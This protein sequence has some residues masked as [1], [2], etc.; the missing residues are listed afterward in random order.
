MTNID[1]I[2]VIILNIN[3]PEETIKCLKSLYKSTYRDFEVVLVDNGSTDGSVERIKSEFQDSPGRSRFGSEFH[4]GGVEVVAS[5][6]PRCM[7]SKLKIIETGRNLGFHGGV[8]VGLK[9]VLKR[10]PDYILLLNND[11][12]VDKNLLKNLIAG[13]KLDKKIGI[14]G[15]KIYY[16]DD[17]STCSKDRVIWFAGGVIDPVNLTGGHV[18]VGEIDKG[19]YDAPRQVDFIS[20]CCLM[21][22]ADLI[23]KIGLLDERYFLYYDD[24]ELAT[25]AK[26]RGYKCFYIPKAFLW[27]KESISVGGDSP[28]KHYYSSRGHL[29]FV[30]K[31]AGF[32]QKIIFFP[33]LVKKIVNLLWKCIIKKDKLAYYDLLGIRDYFLRRFCKK[34]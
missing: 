30:E 9:Y 3:C 15:P 21:I 2:S 19:Q 29:L 13:F 10:N 20:G 14:V 25:Q 32:E 28:I 11:T 12:I 7:S 34:M 6:P 22:K 17:F 18:G 1:M 27:H 5:P 23:K 8:N 4:L 33:R 24:V 26:K 16:Y 31:N